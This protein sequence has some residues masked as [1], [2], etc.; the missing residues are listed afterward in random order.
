MRCLKVI[1]F[2]DFTIV[3]HNQNIASYSVLLFSILTIFSS[4]KFNFLTDCFILI[5]IREHVPHLQMNFH[6][7]NYLYSVPPAL[8][9]SNSQF[10]HHS[11]SGRYYNFLHSMPT[12]NHTSGPQGYGSSTAIHS[13]DPSVQ[14]G[15]TSF[16]SHPPTRYVLGR[17][18]LYC[19]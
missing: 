16:P 11:T 12:Y 8:G 9:G 17:A 15:Y 18:T 3:L 5:M 1:V 6:Q 19:L 4:L 10:P 7:L 2:W 14:G 13:P